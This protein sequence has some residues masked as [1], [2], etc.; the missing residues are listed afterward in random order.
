MSFPLFIFTEQ[1]NGEMFYNEGFSE[2][3]KFSTLDAFA[4]SCLTIAFLFPSIVTAQEAG[5]GFPEKS[6]NS[7]VVYN[8]LKAIEAST[9][10]NMNDEISG[11]FTDERD[12]QV[13]KWVLIGDQV[14]MGENLN[15]G[16][17]ISRYESPSANGIVEKYCYKNDT[18]Y[19][20][21][22]GGLYRW[23]EMMNYSILEGDQGICPQGWHV[24][25]N[26]DWEDMLNTIG[27]SK[28]ANKLKS[29]SGWSKKQPGNDEYGFNALASGKVHSRTLNH[30]EDLGKHAYF[31]SS[32]NFEITTSWLLMISGDSDEIIHTNEENDDSFSVRCIKDW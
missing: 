22:Y 27:M 17:F 4:L 31:W 20:T 26:K 2:S 14:W 8:D 11:N 25:S 3:M 12:G 7:I 6:E 19:C 1:K 24:P 18:E 21:K 15:Y 30:F 28:S 16:V 29:A 13:Y 23:R 10:S 5:M 9:L 32:T